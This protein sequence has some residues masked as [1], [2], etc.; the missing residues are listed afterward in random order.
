M[1]I[2]GRLSNLRDNLLLSANRCPYCGILPADELDHYLPRSIFKGIS[3]YCRNL[4]PI[5]NKCN[6]S[7]RTASG[8]N[9][10]FFHAYFEK[11]PAIP[12]F[13]CETNFNNNM[14]VINYKVDKKH[15]KPDLGNKL[16]F[17]FTRTKL[18]NRL[19]K[20][21][22]D[23]LFDLKASIELMYDS[24]NDNGVKKLLLKNHTDQSTKFGINFWKTAFLL[25]LSKCD[26]FCKGGFIEHFKKK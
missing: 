20:E 7:K 11:L 17:Q 2:N 23:Y 26:D 14:L 3:V 10:S 19:I 16:D 9:N 25:S 5:C 8:V 6:N 12:V 15:I 4:I 13:V 1:Q 24:D 18:N 21:S 22:N